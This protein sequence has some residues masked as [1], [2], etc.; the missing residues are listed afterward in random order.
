MY[1][2]T[3]NDRDK[4]WIN[5]SWEKEETLYNELH[6]KYKLNLKVFENIYIEDTRCFDVVFP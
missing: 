6:F 3:Q 4:K 2:H 5:E 1:S